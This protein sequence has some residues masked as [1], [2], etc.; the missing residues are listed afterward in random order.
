MGE[1]KRRR[2][3]WLR[4]AESVE[5]RRVKES[6]GRK[7]MRDAEQKKVSN[8]VWRK[9]TKEGERNERGHRYG[10]LGFV[11]GQKG[12]KKIREEKEYQV[13]SC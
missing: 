2:E 13:R 11:V 1:E 9:E 10:W 6:E 8:R 7:K 12:R 3:F 4:P 5:W